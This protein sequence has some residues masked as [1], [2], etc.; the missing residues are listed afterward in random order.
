[1]PTNLTNVTA[2]I[3]NKAS[4]GNLGKYMGDLSTCWWVFL[5]CTAIATIL[6]VTYMFLLKYFAKPIL[7]VSFVLILVGLVAGGAYVFA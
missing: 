7:Y 5:I 4:G 3:I 6:G 1:M 2:T